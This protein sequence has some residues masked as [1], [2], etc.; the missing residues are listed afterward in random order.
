MR[1]IGDVV[2]N[3]GSARR[4][5]AA[6]R[7][8][9]TGALAAQFR[10]FSERHTAL[11]TTANVICGAIVASEVRDLLPDKATQVIDVQDVADLQSFST[12]AN[13][14]ERTTEQ[15][16]GSPQRNEPLIDFAH[17]PGTGNHTAAIDDGSQPVH[18]PVLSDEQ[19]RRELRRSIHRSMSGQR[20]IS[21]NAP[22]RPACAFSL[23]RKG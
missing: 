13:V 15:V 7:N 17:L 12:K 3:V 5:I 6:Y 22:G 18:G 2:R 11:G 19:L 4:W 1:I 21:R 14:A 20:E 10:E 16:P 8:A 9:A 23:N